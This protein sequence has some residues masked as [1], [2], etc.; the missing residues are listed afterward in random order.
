MVDAGLQ[1]REDEL[2]EIAGWVAKLSSRVPFVMVID[3]IHWADTT[4]VAFLEHLARNKASRVL[5]I[6]TQWPQSDTRTPW[7]EFVDAAHCA[8]H[9]LGAL[10]DAA[11]RKLIKSEYRRVA[12]ADVPFDE[13]I[14][15]L[16]VERVGAS[17]MAIRALFGIERT[18]RMIE[19]GSLTAARQTGFREI[20]NLY[21]A[22]TGKSSQGSSR[23]SCDRHW[24]ATSSR[25][26]PS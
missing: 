16:V 3:D 7:Q 22:S 21:S 6:A 11:V 19:Q 5:V 10:D 24:P 1:R 26:R 2:A 20:S 9:N 13:A 8:T 4:L 25:T 14:A 12:A 15:D 18:R 17:P 23:R